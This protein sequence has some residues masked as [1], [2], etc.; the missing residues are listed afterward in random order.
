MIEISRSRARR[1]ND[2]EHPRLLPGPSDGM[3]ILE[4]EVIRAVN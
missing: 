1:R 3:A 4:D 2:D